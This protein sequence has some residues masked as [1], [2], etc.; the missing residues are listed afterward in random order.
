MKVRF[1][2]GG[3]DGEQVVPG[4]IQ[5]TAW[6][7]VPTQGGRSKGMHFAYIEALYMVGIV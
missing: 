7:Y 3:M 4:Y 5:H 6:I 2:A 1:W